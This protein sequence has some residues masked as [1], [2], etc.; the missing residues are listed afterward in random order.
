MLFVF[1]SDVKANKKPNKAK[2]VKT[3]KTKTLKT[4]KEPNIEKG[5]YFALYTR[6]PN[7]DCCQFQS[8][9]FCM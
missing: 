6:N 4:P 9:G 7:C 2:T 8:F 1:V 3:Q 5:K